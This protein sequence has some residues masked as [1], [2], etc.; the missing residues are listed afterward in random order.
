MLTTR[1]SC[2]KTAELIEMSFEMWILG[3]IHVLG[4]SPDLP[5]GQGTFFGGGVILGHVQTCLQSIF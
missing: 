3:P 2:A 1:V 4:R 5:T